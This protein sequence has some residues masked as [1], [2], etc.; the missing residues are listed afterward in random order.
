VTTAHLDG[1]SA[2]DLFHQVLLEDTRTDPHQ[3]AHAEIRNALIAA[4]SA[5]AWLDGNPNRIEYVRTLCELHPGDVPG[6]LLT[7]AGWI[8]DATEVGQ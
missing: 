6:M 2:A 3:H 8:Q 4:C 7:A 5:L 1:R